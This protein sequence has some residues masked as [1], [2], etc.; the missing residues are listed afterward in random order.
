[1]A[2]NLCISEP[3]VFVLCV[4]FLF[5]SKCRDVRTREVGIQEIHHKVRPYQVGFVSFLGACFRHSFLCAFEV[6]GP[7]CCTS[8]PVVCLCSWIR[9]SIYFLSMFGC[10]FFK[11]CH[12]LKFMDHHVQ[13]TDCSHQLFEY[14]HYNSFFCFS[15]F[16]FLPPHLKTTTTT[17][18]DLECTKTT[19]HAY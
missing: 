14:L 4:S 5:F 10:L 7:I 2:G 1:M 12:V 13:Q 9:F 3:N 6:L 19:V 18:K 15:T 17:T 16:P 8:I 11:C